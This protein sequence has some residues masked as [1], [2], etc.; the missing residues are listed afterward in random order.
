[1]LREGLFVAMFS[2]L[3]VPPSEAIAVALMLRAVEI[4]QILLLFFIWYVDPAPLPSEQELR[5]D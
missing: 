3:G 4:A 5:S 2:P 1:G